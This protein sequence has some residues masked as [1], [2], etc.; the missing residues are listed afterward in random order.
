[1]KVDLY[2]KVFKIPIHV[3]HPVQQPIVSHTQRYGLRPRVHDRT[4]PERTSNLVDGNFIIRMLYLNAYWLNIGLRYKY[5]IF[6]TVCRS[7][8]SH[9]VSKCIMSFCLLNDYW[10]IVSWSRCRNFVA[11]LTTGSLPLSCS[12]RSASAR[13]WW[14]NTFSPSPHAKRCSSGCSSWNS[15]LSTW[16]LRYVVHWQ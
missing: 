14:R 10:L 12:Q 5:V 4:L 6:F 9:C 7:Y 13:T 11:R 1:M 8:I 16:T 3:L 2:N 15:R